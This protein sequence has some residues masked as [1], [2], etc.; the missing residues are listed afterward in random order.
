MF[1]PGRQV[2]ALWK[3]VLKQ[4]TE[5]RYIVFEINEPRVA[6]RYLWVS[7]LCLFLSHP[8]T[9][10]DSRPAAWSTF[11]TL[12]S[13]PVLCY[14][15]SFLHDQ[16]GC[17]VIF[18]NTFTPLKTSGI[19][20]MLNNFFYVSIKAHH[21]IQPHHP[22]QSS[23]VN[24]VTMVDCCYC[25]MMHLLPQSK[26]CAVGGRGSCA[27]ISWFSPLAFLSSLPSIIFLGSMNEH[28]ELGCLIKLQLYVISHAL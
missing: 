16:N 5:V 23:I 28:L 7:H 25:D 27:L 2:N 4:L 6:N 3:S 24:I 18:N 8:Y 14:Q 10:S 15:F 12:V 26:A 11:Q 13:F 22:Y 20:L 9:H 17:S 1:D 19:L 21:Y